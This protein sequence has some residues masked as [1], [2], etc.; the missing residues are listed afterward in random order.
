MV[1]R[2]C[3]NSENNTEYSAKEM[4]F[5]FRDEFKYFQCNDCDCLQI[6]IVPEDM[7][8]YYPEQYYSFGSYSGKKFKGLKGTIRCLKY[9]SLIDH[10]SPF[11][12]IVRYITGKPDYDLFKE[13]KVQK[14]T[15]ILDVGCG[16][17]QNFLYPL[18]EV[19]YQNILG[20]DPYLEHDISYPN[21]LNIKSSS[22]H[23]MSDVWD[24]IT[25]HH[26]FEHIP[27]PVENLKSAFNL[28]APNGV[29]IIRIP[30]V[31]SFAWGHYK[32][33]WVQ[34]DAPRHF[35]LHSKKSMQKL[36]EIVGLDFFKM[37]CDSTH[38]QFTGSE[39]YI[40]D[41]PLFEQKQKGFLKTIQEGIKKVRRKRHAKRLNK[42]ERGDQAAFYFRRQIK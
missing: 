31:S 35:F 25:F 15:R 39:G 6:A 11:H 13:L 18:A 14:N 38:F 36:A 7:S 21:G 20:C 37:K 22:I 3:G 8:R 27:D 1:C 32:T 17:G 4:M 12:K 30:T 9:A 23:D 24:V 2:V 42:Q 33:N 41:I 5:G 19:G 28:L 10:A 16:N 29:C 34:L 26:S 40:D